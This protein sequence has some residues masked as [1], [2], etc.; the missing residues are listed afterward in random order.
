M[1]RKINANSEKSLIKILYTGI[2]SIKRKSK[3][4]S[5]DHFGLFHW[6]Y[7]SFCHFFIIIEFNEWR[8]IAADQV[9]GLNLSSL[10]WTSLQ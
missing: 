9:F 6:K 10:S 5:L 2:L 4:R 3:Q 8:I 1:A 7:L